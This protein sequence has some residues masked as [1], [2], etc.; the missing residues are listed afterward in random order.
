MSSYHSC[1]PQPQAAGNFPLSI[2]KVVIEERSRVKM[3]VG[4]RRLLEDG[5]GCASLSGRVE[6]ARLDCKTQQRRAEG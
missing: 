5:A 2:R 3:Y 4:A 1:Q 6:A